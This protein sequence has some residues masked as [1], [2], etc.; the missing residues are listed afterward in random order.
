[1]SGSKFEYVRS[2]ELRNDV[3]LRGTWMVVRLDGR[4]FKAFTHKHGFEKPNDRRALGVMNDSALACMREFG[5]IVMSYGQSDEYSF[6]FSRSTNLFGRRSSKIISCLVSYF[7][8]AYVMNWRA[9]FQTP[10]QSVPHFDGRVVLYPS[11]KNVQDYFSWRQADCH[12]NNL[13]NTCF[14]GIIK[15]HGIDTV[16]A[17]ERL[18]GTVSSDKHSILFSECG[19][20]YNN[21][22]AIYRKGSVIIRRPKQARPKHERLE[23]PEETGSSPG[24]APSTDAKGNCCTESKR[25]N[26]KV[27]HIDIIGEPFWESMKPLLE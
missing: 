14:W 16:A 19:I 7:T 24:R 10:L 4:G 21:E 22:E 15:T 1:M 2:F 13:Y 11:L 20:N 18:K 25:S 27:E 3:C 12:I 5:D 26:L 6:V 8:A 9:Y 23:Q 17:Q